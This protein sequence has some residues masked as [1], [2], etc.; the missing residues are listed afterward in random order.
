L[1]FQYSHYAEGFDLFMPS[2]SALCFEELV[3]LHGEPIT[4]IN[5]TV[6][7][8]N[9]YGHPVMTETSYQ[10]AGF[11]RQRPGES[12]LPS[13]HIKKN[14]ISLLLKQWIPVEEELC[15]LEIEGKRYH[16]T[17]LAKT[18]AYLEVLAEREVP[19]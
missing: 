14:S 16:V 7:R 11:L 6:S 15:E 10:E 13:G 9:N 18:E 12:T 1:S 17:G 2:P 4:I 5:Q 19:S 3:E 8:Y